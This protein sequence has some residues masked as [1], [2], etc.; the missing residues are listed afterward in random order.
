MRSRVEELAGAART[1]NAFLC[2]L[3]ENDEELWDLFDVKMCLTLDDTTIRGRLAQRIG[4]PFGKAPAELEAL[5]LS[6]RRPSGRFPIDAD[7]V[8]GT[9]AQLGPY[10]WRS[11]EAIIEPIPLA[12][13]M[14]VWAG[15]KL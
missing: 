2:G 1:Q 11:W 6:L 10:R 12:G 9:P 7:P 15:T 3:V 4:N 14:S 5:R 13:Y 8:T